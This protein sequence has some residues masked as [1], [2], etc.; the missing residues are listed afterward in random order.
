MCVQAQNSA[1]E[2]AMQASD[3]VELPAANQAAAAPIEV[4]TA[5]EAAEASCHNLEK[6]R[7]ANTEQGKTW[8]TSGVASAK[9]RVKEGTASPMVQVL[10][11]GSQV[12]HTCMMTTT[13]TALST[14][15]YDAA[16]YAIK[17]QAATCR[18]DISPLEYAAMQLAHLLCGT[19]DLHAVANLLMNRTV[20]RCKLKDPCWCQA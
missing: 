14:A 5:T 3:E 18:E 2:H 16:D 12:L 11:L 8:P 4:S 17:M 19:L 1:A 7:R 13:C 6:P 15:S 20:Q 9:S 10:L